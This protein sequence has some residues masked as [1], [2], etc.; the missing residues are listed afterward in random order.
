[1]RFY[2]YMVECANGAFYTGWSN[3]PV[4]REKTHNAGRGARY[5]RMN[6]PVRLVYVEE[7]ADK[8]T[9]L[10]RELDIKKLSHTAKGKLIENENNVLR[11]I[12][13][14]NPQKV[15]ETKDEPELAD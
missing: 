4:R 13:A 15:D 11:Q 10:K 8:A 3:D 9:A 7:V 5:T 12:L 1:M 6:G 14:Q 2:C